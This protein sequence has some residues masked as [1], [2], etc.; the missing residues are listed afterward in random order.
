MSKVRDIHVSFRLI[1]DTLDP[2]SVTKRLGLTPTNAYAKGEMS[3]QGVVTGTSY[4]RRT[5]MWRLES[6]LPR[7]ADLNDHIG[8]LLNHLEQRASTIHEY[9]SIGYTVEFLCGLLLEHGNESVD[10]T[11]AVM[12]RVSAI[13]ATVSLDIY[14]P[15]NDSE[16]ST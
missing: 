4:V 15:A 13:G 6:A 9:R 2:V 1:A 7:T 5:G 12:A 8:S 10:L 11:S 16:E 14:A 3:P